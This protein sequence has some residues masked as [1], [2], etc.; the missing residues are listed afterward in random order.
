[1][2]LIKNARVY[3][4]N[5]PGREA[6]AK[7]LAEIPHREIRL[8]EAENAGF[9]PVREGECWPEE[10]GLTES[11]PGGVAFAVRVDKK[12]LPAKVV[13]EE[14]KKQVKTQLEQSGRAHLSKAEKRI[15]REQVVADLVRT[16]HVASQTIVSFYH[17]ESRLLFVPVASQNLANRVTNLL[18][19]AVGAAKTETINISDVKGGLT[20]RLN[21]YLVDAE[22]GAPSEAFADFELS[23]EI[24]LNGSQGKVTYQLRDVDAGHSEVSVRGLKDA[25]KEGMRVDAIRLGYGAASFKL[26]AGFNFKSIWYVGAEAAP[27]DGDDLW[28]HEASVQT[29]SMVE[30]VNALCY[31]FDYKEPAQEAA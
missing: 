25:L 2:N 29:L 30:A 13:S 7:H 26:T 3:R 14:V 4:I 24:W 5:L 15:I 12:V 21:Q 17:A 28:R 6:L 18:V 22:S 9:V 10:L 31:M 23:G 16:S 20:T 19:N 1:M 27:D 8:T 11:F